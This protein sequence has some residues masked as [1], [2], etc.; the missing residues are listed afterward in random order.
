M[1][2]IFELFLYQ[3][4]FN[5]FVSIYN[6]VPDVGA[7]IVILTII[8]KLA[9]HPFT[10]KSVIAQKAL[11]DLQPKLAEIKKKHKGD[12]QAIAQETMALYK[13]NKVNPF[14]SCL[15]ILIQLPVFLALYWVLRAGLTTDNF[16][17]LYS[18]VA[19]PGSI[20]TFTIG[21]IDLSVPNVY[22]AVMAGL[23]QFWQA[24]TMSTKKAPKA[25]GDGAADED[26]MAMV[27]KQM[28]YF[29]PVITVFI[30]MSFPGGLALYWFLSTLFTAAHQQ[31][32]FKKKSTNKDTNAKDKKDGV[33]EGKIVD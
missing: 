2:F 6:V 3:P 22:L 15:P 19:N 5:L 8:V 23:A 1:K 17:L 18:F 30:G 27:N 16:D 24:K 7:A 32:V 29:M 14:G 21:G 33:I 12:Q 26:T 28:L 4:L 10:S 13:E 11:Q 31:I 25:A 9:L 20:N